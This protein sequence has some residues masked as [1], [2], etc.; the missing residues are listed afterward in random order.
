MQMFSSRRTEQGIRQRAFEARERQLRQEREEAIERLRNVSSFATS[1][2]FSFLL[3]TNRWKP[4]R[5]VVHRSVF[6]RIEA[7]ACKVF[8]IRPVALKSNRRNQEIVL[9]RQFVMYWALRLT[10]LSTVQVGRLMGGRD[11]TTVLHGKKEY[12]RKR[13]KMGRTLRSVR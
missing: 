9:A 5:I 11:H 8:K 2:S 4:D 1:T 3:R 13:A 12:Q 10:S 6:Q 7:R